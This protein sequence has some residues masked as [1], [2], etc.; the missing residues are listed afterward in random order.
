MIDLLGEKPDRRSRFCPDDWQPNP[1]KLRMARVATGV[2][3]EHELFKFRTYEF[4]TPRSDW[5][6]AFLNWLASAEP[7]KNDG[8][9]QLE[10][11]TDELLGTNR[12]TQ[13]GLGGDFATVAAHADRHPGPNWGLVPSHRPVIDGG[14]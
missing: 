14:D 5:D 2:D 11:Q 1:A 9:N 4:K 8:R 3:I 6:R 13:G 10:R 12:Q 7:R